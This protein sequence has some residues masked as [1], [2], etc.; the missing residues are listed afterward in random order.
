MT[1]PTE[2]ARKIW[3]W[4]K[5]ET[6]PRFRLSMFLSSN[7]NMRRCA[8]RLYERFNY[9]AHLLYYRKQWIK[10]YNLFSNAIDGTF[11]WEMLILSPYENKVLQAVLDMSKDSQNDASIYATMCEVLSYWND[12]K[13]AFVRAVLRGNTRPINADDWIV[14]TEYICNTKTEELIELD[15]NL[16]FC[17]CIGN[18]PAASTDA[19]HNEPQQV[20]ITAEANTHIVGGKVGAVISDDTASVSKPQQTQQPANEPQQ[21]NLKLLSD[22]DKEKVYQYIDK[23]IKAGLMT[24][25]EIGYHWNGKN[26][27]LAYFLKCLCTATAKYGIIPFKEFEQLFCIKNLHQSLGQINYS[28]KQL[29]WKPKIDD[30]FT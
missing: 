1:T 24:E 7:T 9:S 8:D 23:A 3:D 12:I 4:I 16:D 17:V 15:H 6:C 29:K 14:E 2:Q 10:L 28:S 21:K 22:Y 11:V 5:E 30:I 18:L 25:T 20:D 26:V 19:A 13:A 27:A